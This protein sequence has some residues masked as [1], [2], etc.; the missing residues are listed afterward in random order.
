MPA[1]TAKRTA[2]HA[3]AARDTRDAD[4]QC[5]RAEQEQR[6]HR[7]SVP[8]SRDIA[9]AGRQ[10]ERHQRGDGRGEHDEHTECP[11]PRTE[12]SEQSAGRRTDQRAD[13]P[14]RRDECGRLGPQRPRQCRIDDRIAKPREH[15]TRRSLYDAAHQ[16][17]L[18]R[19]GDRAEQAAQA[20]YC[21]PRQVGP[22]WP[23]PGQGGTHGG[24]RHHRR[25]QIH[26]RH[27]RVEP[28]TADVGD[29]A[30]H[31]AD[32]EKLVGRI[33]R[34]TAGEHGGGPKVLRAQQLTPAARGH[35]RGIG[36]ARHRMSST[37]VEVKPDAVTS[38][39][40]RPCHAVPSSG[41]E[42]R[43]GFARPIRTADPVRR[44][45]S[46]RSDP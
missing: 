44:P 9:R 27:P 1:P 2:V 21:E 23:Q 17:Q 38:D 40:R 24:R 20:E 39:P 13:P 34:H 43:R 30:G 22:P 15:P 11:T 45:S 6:P 46:E 28:L 26:R 19:G 29:R 33:Q 41:H 36:H 4:R 3:H 14:H 10:R 5:R 18:H 42:S 37:F 16:Q 7:D 25:D 31:Q 35:R 8:H 12:L 32:G